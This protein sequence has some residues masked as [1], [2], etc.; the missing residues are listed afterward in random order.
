MLNYSE[1]FER[2]LKA[3]NLKNSSEMAKI[4]GITPQAISNYRKKSELP[5]GFVF[6][7]AQMYG[8]SVDWLLTG[9]GET[10]RDLKENRGK[11]RVC[12][13]DMVEP[14]A[15]EDTKEGFTAEMAVLDP[16]E[17]IYIGKLLKVLRGSEDF[18]APAVKTSIDAFFKT[19]YPSQITEEKIR[20]KL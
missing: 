11:S 9:E 8:I 20:P 17:M 7:F 14:H 15:K 10:F 13:I 12:K 3:G 2:M 19:V 5:A 6:K 1:I 16:D 4:L 18:A